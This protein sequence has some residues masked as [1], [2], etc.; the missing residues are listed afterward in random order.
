[1]MSAFPVIPPFGAAL[2]E[3]TAKAM[4]V[5]LHI[6]A[7][8]CATTTF[9]HYLRQNADRLATQGIGYWGPRRTRKGLFSGLNPGPGAATGRD[10]QRRAMGRVRMACAQSAEQGLQQLLVSDENIMGSVRANLRIGALYSGVGERVARIAQAFDGCL[11]GIVVGIRSQDRYWASALG[12]GVTRGHGV[13]GQAALDRLATAPR[14]WR[15]V[16]TDVA[17]GAGDVPVRVLPFET[18]AGR[19][20]AQLSVLCGLDAPR[21]HAR[22]WLNATPRLDDLRAMTDERGRRLLPTGDGRWRPFE[23]AQAAA[24]RETYADDIMWLTAGA[25]GLARLVLDPDTMRADQTRPADA[26]TRGRHHDSQDRQMARA[27]RG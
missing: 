22:V 1:M 21:T 15:D 17:C 8:R 11:A 7:H 26:M 14:S 27:R 9:Q 10:L 23:G 2:I 5:I 19:P 25:D 20:D 16:I 3:R 6:G 24:L 4:R 13:P 12:Y 18:F